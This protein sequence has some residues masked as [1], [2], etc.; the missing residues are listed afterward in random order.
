M[1]EF[2]PTLAESRN[3]AGPLGAVVFVVRKAFEAAGASAAE[4]NSLDAMTEAHFSA[5]SDGDCNTL[6]E[7]VFRRLSEEKPASSDGKWYA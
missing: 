3:L 1:L 5:L 6:C 7:V 4:L 2:E